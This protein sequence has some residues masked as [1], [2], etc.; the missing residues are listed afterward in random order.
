MNR[1]LKFRIWDS[2]DKKFIN[3]IPYKEY[4]L[5]PDSDWD[6]RDCENDEPF[7]YINGI[8]ERTFNG[9]LII[10]QFTGLLDKNGKEIY[11]GDI[12]RV[13]TMEDWM[14][15]TIY[16][17]HMEVK[18]EQKEFGDTDG[19]GFIYVPKDREIVGNV[20]ENSDLLKKNDEHICHFDSDGGF[21]NK[22]GKTAIGV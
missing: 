10:T 8:L 11:E 22:C 1:T 18:W 5:D 6:R 17:R 15:N 4:M 20:F 7:D 19:T 14:D 21:C 12:L 9:R 13:N 3:G 2:I 16:T